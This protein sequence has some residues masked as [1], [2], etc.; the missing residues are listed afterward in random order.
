MNTLPYLC[1]AYVAIAVILTLYAGRLVWRLHAAA[2][3]SLD[4]REGGAA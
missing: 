1:L 3:Q 4:D 2:R